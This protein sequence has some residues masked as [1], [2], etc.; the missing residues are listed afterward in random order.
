MLDS[1]VLANHL[2]DY[3]ASCGS[4]VSSEDFI[5]LPDKRNPEFLGISVGFS[6]KGSGNLDVF[7]GGRTLD[8]HFLGYVSSLDGSSDLNGNKDLA[9]VLE[10]IRQTSQHFT[11][12]EFSSCE[13]GFR[14]SGR[15]SL[16]SESKLVFTA[17]LNRC[18]R[19]AW[20]YVRK[21]K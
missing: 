3:L 18:L 17:V 7:V 12:T 16:D 21:Q 20:L 6:V 2:S 19:P 11:P 4:R 10:N 9:P 1:R 14:I 8:D 15:Y 5:F 13:Y